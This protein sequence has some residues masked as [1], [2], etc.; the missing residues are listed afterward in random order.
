ML[1]IA[2]HSQTMLV[3]DRST[4]GGLGMSIASLMLGW[5][6]MLLAA[7]G[8][9]THWGDRP[10]W[11]PYGEFEAILVGATLMVMGP[12]TVLISTIGIALGAGSLG[13]NGRT[14]TSTW[15]SIIGILMSI[16]SLIILAVIVWRFNL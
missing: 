11:E 15:M 1:P 7:G 9:W 4:N 8:T 12:L 6:A 14:A 13:N 16:V 2:L 5:V 3:P 10:T